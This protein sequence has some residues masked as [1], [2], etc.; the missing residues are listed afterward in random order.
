LAVALK[1]LSRLNESARPMLAAAEAAR[2]AFAQTE[3]ARELMPLVA[4][5]AVL[6]FWAK[7]ESACSSA[8]PRAI[9]AYPMRCARAGGV[10][11]TRR[12]W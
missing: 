3:E 8:P 1:R 11:P 10:P 5:R 4:H 12:H 6:W 7:E 2:R 9:T